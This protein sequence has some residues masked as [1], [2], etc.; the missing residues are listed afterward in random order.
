[1]A[2]I[3]V[4]IAL[5]GVSYAAIKLPKNS[6][7]AKQLKGNAVTTAKIKNRAVTGAKI[8]TG[9]LGTVPSAAQATSAGHATSADSAASA[10]NATALGG[11]PAKQYMTG[12][13][14]S[15]Q[16]ETGVFGTGGGL[17]DFLVAAINFIPRL[18]A[19]LDGSHA[20]YLPLGASDP[21]CPGVG[22]ADPGFLCVYAGG[23]V[24]ISFI[25]FYPPDATGGS[26]TTADGA[27]LYFSPTA[28]GSHVR[29]TWAYRAP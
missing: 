15:G 17:G 7:G 27:T 10:Q 21:N 4:F 23:E 6:V 8:N 12:I 29:G 5:G 14:G 25:G 20:V 13:L 26:G 1:M 2:T 3:A 18:P 16:T 19:P 9:S 22:K 24:T 28:D 11:V